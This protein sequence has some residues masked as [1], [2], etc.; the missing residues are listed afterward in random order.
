MHFP[1]ISIS[2]KKIPK[3]EWA[4]SLSYDDAT[5]AYFT[6]YYGELYPA[7]ERQK[8]LRSA[9]FKALFSGL[10]EVDSGKGEIRVFSK[11]QIINTLK[12]YYADLLEE[13]QKEQEEPIGWSTFYKL[14]EQGYN[15][16][17]CDDLFVV[18]GC[19]YTSMQFIEDLLFYADKTLY[20][21]NIFDAHY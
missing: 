7:N 17:H 16:K 6:D 8:L 18:D 12:S 11:E 10:A 9:G 15:Y 2:T 13:L 4:E 14:R 1:I 3:K 21:E 20:I 19:S 5:L